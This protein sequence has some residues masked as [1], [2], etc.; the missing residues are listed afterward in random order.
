MAHNTQLRL[1]KGFADIENYKDT[2]WEWESV[3]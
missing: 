2:M 3:S 1:F